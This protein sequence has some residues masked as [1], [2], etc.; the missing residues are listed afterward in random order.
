MYK[1]L[2]LL[3][4]S[5]FSDHSKLS[6][7]SIV[8]HRLLK[9]KCIFGLLFERNRHC[10]RLLVCL[11]LSINKEALTPRW[12]R[13]RNS[14]P[15]SLRL[16][17]CQRSRHLQTSNMTYDIFV[18]KKLYYYYYYYSILKKRDQSHTTRSAE[19]LKRRYAQPHFR[20]TWA[21]YCLNAH[22]PDNF[23]PLT[24]DWC[25]SHAVQLT[26]SGVLSVLHFPQCG[27]ISTLTFVCRLIHELS[28]SVTYS[29]LQACF[30]LA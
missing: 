17:S 18:D 8:C 5:T 1:K 7:W 13:Q 19:M 23:V 30:Q 11:S 28:F 10:L 15:P 2:R 6:T 24:W 27:T 4:T 9:K 25:K 26:S 22:Q 21:S 12:R 14:L 3:V 16:R 29:L 20:P